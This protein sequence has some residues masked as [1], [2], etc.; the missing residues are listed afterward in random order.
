MSSSSSASAL[1]TIGFQASVLRRSNNQLHAAECFANEDA[2]TTE[3]KWPS[4]AYSATPHFLVN[5]SKTTAYLM[6]EA[7]PSCNTTHISRGWVFKS[8]RSVRTVKASTRNDR[9]VAGVI[10]WKLVNGSA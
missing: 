2:D 8:S 9:I 7:H 4:P 6:F 10:P 1:E 3:V 5:G